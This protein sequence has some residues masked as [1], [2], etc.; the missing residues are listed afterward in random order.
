MNLVKVDAKRIV[1]VGDT[2]G[3]IDATRKVIE[4]FLDSKTILIFLGDYVDRGEYSKENIDYL[5]RLQKTKRVILLMGNHEAYKKIQ[6]APAKFWEEIRNTELYEYY[7]NTLLSL[8]LIAVGKHFIALHG[9]LPEVKS[10][11][12][13]RSIN[14][15][16]N[17]ERFVYT[18]WG[19]I[20]VSNRPWR[21]REKVF[22][23]LKTLKK[24]FLIRAHQYNVP[25]IISEN[26]LKIVTLFTTNA[27]GYSEKYLYGRRC[28]AILENDRLEIKN[29]DS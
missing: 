6:F 18:I 23:T 24:R 16:E 7:A 13:L 19:D 1:F 15:S 29:I 26:N 14:K 11:N 4:T 17:D 28:V 22:S 5:L 21:S 10:I 20:G 12:E 2:H 25:Q 3:D 9:I 8:P 27:Y